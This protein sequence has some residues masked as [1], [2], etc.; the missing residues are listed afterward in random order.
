MGIVKKEWKRTMERSRS[1]ERSCAN[2]CGH[3]IF[4]FSGPERLCY[5]HHLLM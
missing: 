2:V 4:D 3:G 1:Y 5:L